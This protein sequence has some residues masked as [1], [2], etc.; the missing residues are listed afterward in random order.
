MSLLQETGLWRLGISPYLINPLHL[1][2]EMLPLL[3]RV[4]FLV[5]TE[6][7]NQETGV[8]FMS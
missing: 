7:E 1:S 6:D 8:A 2:A 5:A 4:S 3:R